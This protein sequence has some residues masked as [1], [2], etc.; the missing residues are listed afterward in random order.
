MDFLKFF[1]KH[2][3]K[4]LLSVVLGVLAIATIFLLMRVSA[5]R[6]VLD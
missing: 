3:E 5:E 2:Y 1:K 4:V 6:E